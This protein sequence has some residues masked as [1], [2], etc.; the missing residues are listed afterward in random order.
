MDCPLALNISSSIKMHLKNAMGT[1]TLGHLRPATAPVLT[2]AAAEIETLAYINAT[3]F[4]FQYIYGAQDQK[5]FVLCHF[6][7]IYNRKK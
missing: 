5:R 4:Q 7:I 1:V 6:F 2:E 3:T